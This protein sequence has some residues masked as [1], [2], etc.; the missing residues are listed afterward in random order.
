[1][2]TGD[3]RLI[4]ELL[5]NMERYSVILVAVITEGIDWAAYIGGASSIIDDTDLKSKA[6]VV[7]LEG[8][9]VLPE[10]AKIYFPNIKEPYRW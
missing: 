8:D 9:K 3:R 10:V 1:M 4:P 7:A 5:S 2:S 6:Q